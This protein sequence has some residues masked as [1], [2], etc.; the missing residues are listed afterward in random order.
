MIAEGNQEEL[1]GNLKY[2]L[3]VRQRLLS[4]VR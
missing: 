1:K 3:L 4:N 2:D